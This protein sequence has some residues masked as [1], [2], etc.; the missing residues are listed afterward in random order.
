MRSFSSIN[1]Q[2]Q[3]RVCVTWAGVRFDVVLDCGCQVCDVLMC[4][5]YYTYAAYWRMHEY[6][7]YVAYA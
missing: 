5:V 1:K 7:P 2:R 3:A 6:Q 4:D